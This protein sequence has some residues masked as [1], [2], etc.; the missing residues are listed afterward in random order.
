VTNQKQSPHLTTED[1]KNK[2][3]HAAYNLL[4]AGFFFSFINA[5]V[6][7][8]ARY[9][10]VFTPVV[11]IMIRSVVTLVISGS[12]LLKAREHFFPKA[13]LPL[14][15]SRGLF[16]A[17]ALLCNFTTIQKLPLAYAVTLTYLSPLLTVLLGAMINKERFSRELLI[18]LLIGMSGVFLMSQSLSL[19]E[20]SHGRVGFGESDFFYLIVGILAAFFAATAY[21]LIRKIGDRAPTQLVVFYFPLV[22]LSLLSP[23]CWWSLQK[24]DHLGEILSSLSWPEWGGLFMMGLLTQVAQVHM[25]KAYKSVPTAQIGHYNY[26]TVFYA[27]VMGILFFDESYHYLS[28]VAIGLILFSVWM[29]QKKA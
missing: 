17:L 6:K 29:C 23:W 2:R 10:E 4:A 12:L 15:L 19:K 14:L 3:R 24:V 9:E 8:Y 5:L 26:V 25:T 7:Y 27:F 16:G 20:S 22:S 13:L 1:E 21:V 11:L 18:Y 28:L